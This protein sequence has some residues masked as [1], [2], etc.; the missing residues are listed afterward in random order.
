MEP[1][2]ARQPPAPERR[3]PRSPG[4]RFAPCPFGAVL[5][6]APAQ[7]REAFSRRAPPRAR[8]SAKA[9]RQPAP[10]ITSGHGVRTRRQSASVAPSIT[11]GRGARSVP[12][13]PLRPE[14]RAASGRVE[15]FRADRH[16]GGRGTRPVRSPRGRWSPP[17]LSPRTPPPSGARGA[18]PSHLGGRGGSRVRSGQHSRPSA[19]LG[20]EALSRRATLGHEE[21]CGCAAANTHLEPHLGGRGSPPG[22][23]GCQHPRR[24]SP[25]AMDHY[26]AALY[27]GAWSPA[28]AEQPA[29]APSIASGRWSSAGAQPPVPAPRTTSEAVEPGRCG[30]P[31]PA[32][33]ITSGRWSPDR[34]QEPASRPSTTSEAVEPGQV[35]AVSTR[36]TPP[37]G[38]PAS[39]PNGSHQLGT[40]SDLAL[41]IA[42]CQ[43]RAHARAG[44]ASVRVNA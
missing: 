18:R 11:S 1:V 32:P 43:G 39:A 17:G 6:R 19:T 8:K 9:Q 41:A 35:A 30:G 2:D 31:V 15:P 13:R 37:Q 21:S 42:R 20:R 34:A 29:P 44:W 22:H 4:S 36:R 40:P 28:D 10:G 26:R 27:R 38:N 25:G 33:G 5:R 16:L 12:S 14:H 24:V 3:L 23:G 7:A